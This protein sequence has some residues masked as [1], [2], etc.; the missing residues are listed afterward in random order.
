[1]INDLV[2]DTHILSEF[3]WQYFTN[4]L[5]GNGLLARSNIITDE[6]QKA[7]NDII[8][9]YNNEGTFSKGLIITSAFS[10][11]EIARKFD[12]IAF[13]KFTSSQFKIFLE[14]LPEYFHI[15]PLEKALSFHLHKVPKVVYDG[16]TQKPIELPDAIH[17]ATYFSRDSATLITNDARIKR[18]ENINCL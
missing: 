17:C 13:Q 7:I 5:R 10:V 1:M 11:I 4:D 3:I 8:L 9:E 6:R 18:I 2:F 14:E 15:A 12:I 16:S